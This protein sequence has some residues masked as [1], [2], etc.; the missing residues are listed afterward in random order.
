LS[1]SARRFPG[2]AQRD[3]VKNAFPGQQARVLKHDA[4]VTRQTGEKFVVD[5]DGASRGLLQPRHQ[6]QQGA[7]AAAAATHDR[8]E[9]AR[10]NMQLRVLQH[11][12]LAKTFA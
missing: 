9:L 5:S 1:A 4:G 6:T 11:L 8:N 2:Q 12:A 7:F 10:L 3:V